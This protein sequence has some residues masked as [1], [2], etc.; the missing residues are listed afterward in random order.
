MPGIPH[1]DGQRSLNPVQACAW[2]GGELEP[3]FLLLRPAAEGG[4]QLA[5]GCVCF[6][7]SWGLEEKIGLGMEAIHAVV[8]GLNSAIGRQIDRFLD[9]LRPGI[10]W[11]R[12]NWGLSRSGER[13]QHPS[14]NLPRLDESVPLDEVFFRV[15]HQS[16]ASLPRSGG[17]LFGIRISTRP[18]TEVMRVPEVRD[19]LIRALQT[20][21]E[22][23]AAYKNLAR[24]RES[25]L[26]FLRG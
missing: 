5:A 12:T 8:P 24:C 4:M 7:S 9:R 18:L 19:G 14:R 6:P 10:S 25:I 11:E 26:R 22:E 23:M 17:G 21:P 1:P 15:E 2:L 3:D 13:N 16:L 20:M